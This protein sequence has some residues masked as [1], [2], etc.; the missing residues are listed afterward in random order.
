MHKRSIVA[1]TLPPAGGIP[2]LHRI[3]NPERSIARFIR[4]R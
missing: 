1:T 3:E 2:D 4:S